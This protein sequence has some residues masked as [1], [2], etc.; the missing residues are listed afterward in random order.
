MCSELTPRAHVPDNRIP[1]LMQPC[2]QKLH[3]FKHYRC[4]IIANFQRLQMFKH[5]RCSNIADV[6]T[7]QM[8]K[9]YRCSK[10]AN[11][12]I[13][14]QVLADAWTPRWGRA[15]VFLCRVVAD[16]QGRRLHLREFMFGSFLFWFMFYKYIG[17]WL[18]HK[19]HFW[20]LAFTSLLYLSS[21]FWG[22]L[23]SSKTIPTGLYLTNLQTS[24]S[25]LNILTGAHLPCQHD[26]WVQDVPPVLRAGLHED[27]AVQ[28]GERQDVCGQ[29]D[30]FQLPMGLLGL[31]C[32][33][34][35]SRAIFSPSSA[36]THLQYELLDHVFLLLGKRKKKS[37]KKRW[38][39]F[40]HLLPSACPAVLWS[41]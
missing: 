19:V 20:L 14:S 21:H 28:E 38:K 9:H 29:G 23:A 37:R 27:G 12:Q 1:Q 33:N 5:C 8:F 10:T 40:F 2:N 11:I 30:K 25:Y 6:Q 32:C 17:S 36:P 22:N 4:S 31:K 26:Q 13:L 7:L 16:L 35:Y 41:T 24:M 18:T 15:A 34:L 39:N 3:M